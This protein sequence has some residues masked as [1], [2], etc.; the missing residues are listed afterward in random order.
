M[1]PLKYAREFFSSIYLLK[2]FDKYTI[3]RGLS[4]DENGIVWIPIEDVRRFITCY[5][6][7]N[8][9]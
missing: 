6:S 1:I 7:I 3:G 9:K 8:M 5:T 2:E 4:T